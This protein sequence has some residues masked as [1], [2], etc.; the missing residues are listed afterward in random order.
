MAGV[1]VPTRVY[2]KCICGY[3]YRCEVCNPQETHT[4]STGLRVSDGLIYLVFDPYYT[5]YLVL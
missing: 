2:A 4:H 3:G 1:Y 5:L